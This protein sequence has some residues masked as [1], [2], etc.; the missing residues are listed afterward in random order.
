MFNDED[1]FLNEMNEMDPVDK[2]LLDEQ[3]EEEITRSMQFA[4]SM[5]E[6]LG[7]EIWLNHI[8]I[9]KDRK[10]TILSNM[11]KWHELREEFEKCVI[12]KIG[13]DMIKNKNLTSEIK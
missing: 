7:I 4:F 8:D 13:L 5:I 1:D 6:D 11:L 3:I 2:I 9:A 10:I 12:L